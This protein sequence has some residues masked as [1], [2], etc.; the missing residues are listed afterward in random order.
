MIHLLH[1]K[2]D[3]QVR[4]ALSV[5]RED[6]AA[7]DDMLRTNTTVLEGRGLSPDELLAHVTAAPFLAAHRL[8]IVEGLLRALGEVRGGRRSKKKA[9]ADDPLEP[10]RRAASRMS[11]PATMPETTTVVLVEGELAKTNPAFPIFAPIAYTTEYGPLPPNELANWIRARAKEKKLKLTDGAAQLL[12][13]L[14]GGDLWALDNEL[15]KLAAYAGGETVDEKTVPELVSS[16]RET[17]VWEL[18][19]AVVAGNERKALTAMGRL[20]QEGEAPQLLLFMVARQYRQLVTLKDLRDRR[21]AR[22]EQQR[23]SGVPGF[24]LNEVGALAGRYTW[25]RLHTAYRMILDADLSVKRGLQDDESA[26]QLLVHELCA[27]AP[28]GAAR[29][30]HAR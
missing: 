24:K 30:S 23:V 26:L 21:V 12:A 1:G 19:D 14:I 28:T 22:E 20:L 3:Y 16:A 17:K 25:P 5:I 27:L 8:V 7:D 6:L 18:A 4:Q 15:D 10:W 9:D 13:N 2:D 29:P 11:D